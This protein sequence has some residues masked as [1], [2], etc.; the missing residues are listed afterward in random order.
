MLTSIHRVVAACIALI[1]SV[2]LVT[3]RADAQT[4]TNIA[5]DLYRFDTDTGTS[6]FLVTPEGIVVVDPLTIETAKW[7]KEELA[8]RFPNRPVRYVIYSHHG[9]DRASG[10][11]ALGEKTVIVAHET[12]RAERVRAASVLPAE[13]LSLDVNHDYVL[14]RVEYAGSPAASRIASFD[15]N[16]DG[17]VTPVEFYSFVGSPGVTFSTQ[18][19]IALGGKQV[20]LHHVRTPS[21]D[22]GVVVQ[23]PDERV[24]FAAD[25]IPL[26]AAPESFGETGVEGLIESARTIE[27]IDF[28]LLLNGR[29]ETGTKAD[30]AT[31]RQY[32]ADA[33]RGVR[34]GFN[35]G[36]SIDQV[37]ATLPLDKYAGLSEFAARR[38]SNIA[39]IYGR[40]R[41]VSFD[42]HAEANVESLQ[43]GTGC[44]QGCDNVGGGTLGPGFGVTLMMGRAAVVVEAS[45]ARPVTVSLPPGGTVAGVP[46]AGGRVTQRL[47]QGLSFLVGY[48][49][50]ESHGRVVALDGGVSVLSTTIGQTT[51][52]PFSGVR[53]AEQNTTGTGIT[54]GIRILLPI[55]ETFKVTV[56]V[57]FT[58][59]DQTPLQTGPFQLRAG[60][61][62]SIRLL[63]RAL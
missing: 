6:V 59:A 56:P 14:E 27:R 10:A 30:V 47:E 58:W 15:L 2:G 17:N 31:F 20:V 24:V 63:R 55:T 61:G 52:I 18:H 48:S 42:V 37:R 35:R 40:L 57:R 3:A 34:D 16:G 9:F 25:V 33:V 51:G 19:T 53:F 32:V 54:G 39:E 7:L 36:Q 5:G 38:P 4:I 13:F 23:F 49:V 29:G 22:D 43:A 26:R 8:S 60:I 28:S 41:V 11:S 50:V 21:G 44:T 62:I 12:F 1:V 45:G 46:I